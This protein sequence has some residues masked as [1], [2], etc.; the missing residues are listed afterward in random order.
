MDM[1]V[2]DRATGTLLSEMRVEHAEDLDAL[3]RAAVEYCREYIGGC[4]T[5]AVMPDGELLAWDAREALA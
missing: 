4:L 1:T 5:I 2:I 3:M